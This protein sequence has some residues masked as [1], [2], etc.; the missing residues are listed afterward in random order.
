MIRPFQLH[1]PTTIAEASATIAELPDAA[2]YRGGTELLQVMKMGLAR[3]DH[4]VDLKRIPELHGITVQSDG[5]I[6]IGGATTH[7]EIERSAVVRGSYPALADLERQVAN[8][9]VRSV[10]SIGG[11]LCFAEPHSD[12]ATFLLVADARLELSGPDG[13]RTLTVDAFLLGALET[14]LAHGELL[15]AIVLPAPAHGTAIAY[16]RIALVERPAASVA[17]RLTIRDGI[18]AEARLAVG[19]VGERPQLAPAAATILDGVSRGDLAAAAVAAAASVAG[20]CDVADEPGTSAEYRR[21]L[22]GV[23][24]RRAILAAAEAADDR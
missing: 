24:A 19:S 3:F 14:D 22:V 21:H 10:G 17:C 8:P 20:A 2:F 18:A 5:S 11:N 1:R 12:P 7:A 23:L 9:R 13:S 15:V 4:L 16:R 6:R